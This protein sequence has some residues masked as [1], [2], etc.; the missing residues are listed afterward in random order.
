LH[1]AQPAIV[2]LCGKKCVQVCSPVKRLIVEKSL[3]PQ[4]LTGEEA[5]IHHCEPLTK[6]QSMEWYIAIFFSNEEVRLPLQQGMS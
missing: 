5:W 3:L 2:K 4:I 1:E 6:R